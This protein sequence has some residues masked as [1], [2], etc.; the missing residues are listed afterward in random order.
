MEQLRIDKS[1][2]QE[3]VN[4]NINLY[5]PLK[6]FNSYQDFE[7]ICTKKKMKNGKF[8][9]I[10]ILFGISNS[11]MSK[12][13]NSKK[14]QII[15]KNEKIALIRNF[16]IFK[17]DQKK[18]LKKIYGTNDTCHP[19]VRLFLKKKYF[20]DGDI[21]VRNKIKNRYSI[22]NIKNYLKSMKYVTGYHTRNIPH[23]G[24]EWIIN[25]GLKKTGAVFINPITGNLKRGDF[26]KSY[27]NKAFRILIKSN[28]K[29]NKN[30]FF[31]NLST[32]A[33][34]AGPREALFHAIIRKN[35]GCSHFLVGRDHAG[36]GSYYK[37]YESQRICKKYEK[38][39]D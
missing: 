21:I 30:I 37:K 20:I 16:K 33:R 38:K 31:E 12:I 9:P 32:H 25:F 6:R 7:N 8:F 34:Y 22:K 4:V 28:Y 26:K 15:Y 35:Y 17:I 24:H 18:Y 2:F 14:I 10:P 3:L 11:Q 19:G 5:H 36:V 1:T 13:K 39:L 29:D 23:K 27:V